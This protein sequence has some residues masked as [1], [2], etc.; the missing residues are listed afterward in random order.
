MFFSIPSCH[1]AIII[2]MISDGNEQQDAGSVF[3]TIVN[4]NNSVF[5]LRLFHADTRLVTIILTLCTFHLEYHRPTQ[6]AW[7]VVPML[8]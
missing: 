5:L 2:T 7:K 8:F 6:Q 4:C 1:A 3:L